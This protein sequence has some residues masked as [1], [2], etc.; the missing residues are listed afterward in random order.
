MSKY[1]IETMRTY[2]VHYVVEAECADTAVETFSERFFP[3]H[4]REEINEKIMW[5][6]RMP[7]PD[8][9]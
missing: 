4:S 1:V 3:E 5:T 2:R 8:S 6:T 9:N 7:D